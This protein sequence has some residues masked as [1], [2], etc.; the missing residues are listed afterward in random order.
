MIIQRTGATKKSANFMED[1]YVERLMQ[2]WEAKSVKNV[3]VDKVAMT[4][5]AIVLDVNTIPSQ[6]LIWLGTIERMIKRNDFYK[7]FIF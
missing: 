7:I 1:K 5:I 6:L 3:A 4:N 2:R